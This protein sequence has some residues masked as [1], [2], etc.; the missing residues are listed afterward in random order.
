MKKRP[1][2]QKP[3]LYATIAFFCAAMLPATAHADDKIVSLSDQR[4]TTYSFVAEDAPT[5]VEEPKVFVMEQSLPVFLR[6]AARRSGY[7]ITLSKRV[8]GTLKKAVLPADIRKIMPEIAEQFDLKWHYQ[9]KQ[10]FVGIGSEE[11]N[12]VI[13]LGRMGFDD[14][15]RAMEQ[16]GFSSETYS[17]SFV[18]ES[19]SVLA[20]GSVAYISNIELLVEAYKK[21][22]SQSKV[23]VKVIRY[24]NVGN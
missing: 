10:L 5:P 21:D 14:L 2:F 12:R 13:F 24:G 15:K 4:T 9:N 7:Q 8:R 18:D 1:D 20:S 16:A 17:L 23:N 19:N 22:K 3:G 11:T 6:Q